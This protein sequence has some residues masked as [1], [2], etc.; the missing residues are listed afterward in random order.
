[1]V[2]NISSSKNKKSNNIWNN[3]R[4]KSNIKEREID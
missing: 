3:K 4:Q 2:T 1:M